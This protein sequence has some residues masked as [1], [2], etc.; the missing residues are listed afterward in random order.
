MK[1]NERNVKWLYLEAWREEENKT[2]IAINSLNE[3]EV[4]LKKNCLS[5]NIWFCTNNVRLYDN[6]VRITFVQIP[7]ALKMSFVWITFVLITTFEWITNNVCLIDNW[8]T[9][10]PK[11]TSLV[12]TMFVLK[13]SFIQ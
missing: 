8:M 7:L 1:E 2:Q 11:K 12:W 3:K 9:F 13:A 10:V 6:Y 4:R 5:E